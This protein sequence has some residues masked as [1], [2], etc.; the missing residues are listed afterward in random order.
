[1]SLFSKQIP[2]PLTVQEIDTILRSYFEERDSIELPESEVSID[3]L[4]GTPEWTLIQFVDNYLIALFNPKMYK[5]FVN[6][7]HQMGDATEPLP[8]KSD[9]SIEFCRRFFAMM[10]QIRPNIS[11]EGSMAVL[12]DAMEE[13]S[14]YE[15]GEHTISNLLQAYVYMVAKV[16]YFEAVTDNPLKDK[17]SAKIMEGVI[18]NN[19]SLLNYY[20]SS[21]KD[22]LELV[23]E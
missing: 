2:S 23:N 17:D 14:H 13:V 16:Q 11:L 7:S 22:M 18:N 21:R 19:P 1:M 12:D 8:L 15:E 20:L 9:R 4:S 5:L 6:M 10:V 3:M